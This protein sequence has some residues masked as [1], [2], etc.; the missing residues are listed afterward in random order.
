MFYQGH[1]LKAERGV[2]TAVQCKAV[3]LQH[4]KC[5][6]WSWVSYEYNIVG[7]RGNC[8]VKSKMENGMEFLGIVSGQVQYC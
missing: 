5:V 4:P 8:H 3:C 7:A 1:D 6:G 2:E